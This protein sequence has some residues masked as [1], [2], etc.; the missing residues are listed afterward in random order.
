MAVMDLAAEF[1]LQTI[2]TV[3]IRHALPTGQMMHRGYRVDPGKIKRVALMT[4][5]GAHDDITGPGQTRAAHD[6][7]PNIP[8]HRR[9]HW[10]QPG[11][12]HFG[13]F[14]G[15]RF[16]AEVLPRVSAFIRAHD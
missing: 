11:V 5:E 7:C 1:Y 6:L 13:V 14:N 9:A 2:D 15:S 3:F 4:I 16:R 12:G 8:E 10:M